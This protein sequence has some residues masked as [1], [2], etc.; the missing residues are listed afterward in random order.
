MV[1]TVIKVRDKHGENKE[2]TGAWWIK[3]LLHRPD[4][5]S[6]IPRTHVVQRDNQHLNCP[7]TPQADCSIGVLKDIHPTLRDPN[8]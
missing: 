8:L 1:V 2:I 7:L 3:C 5:L 4:V 6:L